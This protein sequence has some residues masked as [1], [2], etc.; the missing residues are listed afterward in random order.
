MC[1]EFAKLKNTKI[2][3]G[4]ISCRDWEKNVI[5]ETSLLGQGKQC[6]G[7]TS[8]HAGPLICQ[9]SGTFPM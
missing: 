1:Y 4:L 5:D 7:E 8:T 3:F 2:H 6:V 9:T